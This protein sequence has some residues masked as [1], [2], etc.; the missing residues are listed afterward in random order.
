MTA[1]QLKDR[2]KK[3]ALEI[4]KLANE[5]PNNR[6]GWTF[7]DQIVRSSTSVAANYRAACRAKS[8]RDF[9]SKLETVSEEAD[10][11][12]FWLEMIAESEI[13]KDCSKIPPLIK[14]TDELLSIFVAS[15]KT[16]KNRLMMPKK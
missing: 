3:Y 14:E 11:T 10:E 16:V 5:L 1:E 2:T 4:I 9:I 13:M 12:M 7:S 6:V 8:D 15:K